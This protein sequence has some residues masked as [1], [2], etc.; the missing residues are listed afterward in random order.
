MYTG[1][2]FAPALSMELNLGDERR[3]SAAQSVLPAPQEVSFP[4]K[5]LGQKQRC[6]FTG[7]F[8]LKHKGRPH[9]A[10]S[11]VVKP[12]HLQLSWGRGA[13]GL[14]SAVEYGKK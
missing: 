4:V 8:L 7:P 13:A 11:R 1:T 14:G 6:V 12:L 2:V 5:I 3:A 10:S 9:V